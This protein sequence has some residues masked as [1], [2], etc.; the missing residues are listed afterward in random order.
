M[1]SRSEGRR[2]RALDRRVV[3]DLP[4]SQRDRWL[5]SFAHLYHEVVNA[6]RDNDRASKRQAVSPTASVL[7]HQTGDDATSVEGPSLQSARRKMACRRN[8]RGDE[9]ALDPYVAQDASQSK[10]RC[11]HG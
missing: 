8:L 4:E 2:A 5:V 7:A 10:A 6:A 3:L 1:S 9:I 11:S